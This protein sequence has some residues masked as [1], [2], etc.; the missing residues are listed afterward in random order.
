MAYSVFQKLQGKYFGM[1]GGRAHQWHGTSL[2]A[3]RKIILSFD[4]DTEKDFE[5][6][7]PLDEWLKRRNIPTVYAVPGELLEKGIS[8]Y[9]Q[10]SQSGSEFINHGYKSHSY[11]SKGNYYSSLFYHE[12]GPEDI[13]ND[14]LQGHQC[15]VRLL[16]TEPQ[17]FRTPHFGA[18]QNPVQ[19]GLLY[20]ILK[21]LNYTFSSSTVPLK[22]FT[23]GIPYTAPHGIIEFPVTGCFDYPL[24]ILDSFSFRFAKGRTFEPEEYAVQFKKTIDCYIQSKKN[25]VLNYYADPSQVYDFDEFYRSM[26][27]ALLNGFEFVTF[28]SIVSQMQSDQNP[29]I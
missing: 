21:E 28:R 17:G 8:Y 29:S 9:R 1:I 26:E 19:L 11:F 27:Y 22:Y 3:G 24:A 25:I 7:L 18:F 12:L 10:L 13:R 4:C 5:V 20:S 15:I 6:V 23:S 16:G 14:I 2:I